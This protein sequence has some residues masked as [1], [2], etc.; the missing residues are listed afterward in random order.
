MNNI[1][2]KAESAIWF[3]LRMQICWK[4]VH[5]SGKYK[6]LLHLSFPL[7]PFHLFHLPFLKICG[8]EKFGQRSRGI[9]PCILRGKKWFHAGQLQAADFLSCNDTSQLWWPAAPRKSYVSAQGRMGCC[10]HGARKGAVWGRV[11]PGSVRFCGREAWPVL[12]TL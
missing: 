5:V 9:H 8:S 1:T 6:G 12:G 10:G 4:W 7:F 2:L 11:V 3:T